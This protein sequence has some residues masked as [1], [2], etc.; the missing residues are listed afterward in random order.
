[1]R[2]MWICDE[3][4]HPHISGAWG[5]VEECPG[6][7]CTVGVPTHPPTAVEVGTYFYPPSNGEAL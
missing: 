2:C 5:V 3:C 6:C 4:K 1:M 7:A